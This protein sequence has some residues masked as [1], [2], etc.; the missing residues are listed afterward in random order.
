MKKQYL[1]FILCAV[2]VIGCATSPTGRR[3][4]MI[5]SEER[6]ISASKQAYVEILKPYEQQGKVDNEPAL[7][8]R[9]YRITGRLM[10][11]VA[12]V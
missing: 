4:L 11:W 2:L 6:A 10:A 7:K 12:R 1:T 8:D 5:V 9:V 3:Q